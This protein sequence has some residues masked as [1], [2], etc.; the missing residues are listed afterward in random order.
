VSPDEYA[1]IFTPN[2]TGACRLAG[3]EQRVKH[4]AVERDS[5]GEKRTAREPVLDGHVPLIPHH[6]VL[7]FRSF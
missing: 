7:D 3:E 1:A 2:A 4:R 5:R 6:R